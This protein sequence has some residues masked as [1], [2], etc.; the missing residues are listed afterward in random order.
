MANI[1]NGSQILSYDFKNPGQ[2]E[3]FNRINYKVRSVGI[4]DGAEISKISDIQVEI[5]PFVAHIDDPNTLTGVRVETTVNAVVDITSSRP[6]VIIRFNWSNTANNYADIISVAPED[7]LPNDLI[8]AKVIYAGATLT[9]DYDYS[10]KNWSSFRNNE[11][12]EQEFKVTPTEPYTNTLDVS[13][14]TAQINGDYV[15]YAGGTTPALADT[16]ASYSRI[17]LLTIDET[18]TLAWVVG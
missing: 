5:T 10:F 11:I 12:L 7:L 15:E 4:Y 8:I 2:S 13:S 9:T 16:P 18:G 6:Y 1:D 17:D 3:S 14:G